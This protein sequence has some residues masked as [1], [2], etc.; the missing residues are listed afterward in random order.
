MQSASNILLQRLF[1]SEDCINNPAGNS[2][3]DRAKMDAE[4]EGKLKEN[5]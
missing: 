1:G 5:S 3:L 4:M 2:Y